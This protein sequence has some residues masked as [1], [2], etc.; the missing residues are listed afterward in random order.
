M[1]N[2]IIPQQWMCQFIGTEKERIGRKYYYRRC[3][4]FVFLPCICEPPP[5]PEWRRYIIRARDI[6]IRV[7]A[8]CYVVNRFRN[9]IRIKNIVG[10]PDRITI[11]MIIMILENSP[12]RIEDRNF[13][14]TY[15][16]LRSACAYSCCFNTYNVPN[17]IKIDVFYCGPYNV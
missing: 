16:H 8:V 6:I 9:V 13:L 17:R 4:C 12:V 2:I 11:I 7:C 15:E 5:P 1:Y 14:M 10:N 3:Y